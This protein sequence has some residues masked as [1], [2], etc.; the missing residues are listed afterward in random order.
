MEIRTYEDNYKAIQLLE[1]VEYA[2]R[3]QME[4]RLQKGISR[5][6]WR[7]FWR[8]IPTNMEHSEIPATV[9]ALAYPSDWENERWRAV[10]D[11][12]KIRSR[13]IRIHI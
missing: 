3:V 6:A 9:L 11:M 8:F 1:R 2:Q 4:I 7:Y 12:A 5:L 10:L 13:F